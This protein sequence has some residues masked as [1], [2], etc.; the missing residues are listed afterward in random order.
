MPLPPY[1]LRGTI[2][3]IGRGRYC[4]AVRPVNGLELL[5]KY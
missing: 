2:T 5:D 1:G 4:A 3:V